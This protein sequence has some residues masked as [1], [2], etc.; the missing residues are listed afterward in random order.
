V[1]SL[2]FLTVMSGRC[3]VVAFPDSYKQSYEFIQE[4]ALVFIKAQSISEND[5]PRLVLSSIYLLSDAIQKDLFSKSS[6]NF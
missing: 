5:N 2:L 3:E 6:R 4:D 1:K